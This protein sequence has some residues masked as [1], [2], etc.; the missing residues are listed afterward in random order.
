MLWLFERT[1]EFAAWV[2]MI[3]A[4][5]SAVL[6]AVWLVGWFS[7]LRTGADFELL[8]SSAQASGAFVGF[9]IA[10]GVLACIDRYIFDADQAR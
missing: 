10:L 6:A 7:T 1:V 8:R 9:A 3:A 5:L 2:A 4:W